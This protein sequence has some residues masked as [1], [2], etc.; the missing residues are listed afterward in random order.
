MQP[1]GGPNPGQPTWMSHPGAPQSFEQNV[2]AARNA[3]G[4]IQGQHQQQQQQQLQSNTIHPS[5]SLSQAQSQGNR[6]G[7]VPPRSGPTP[8]Q[9]NQPGSQHPLG[10]FNI[11]ANA[12]GT[13]FSF[14]A[15][16]TP[17]TAS[18]PSLIQ[19]NRPQ[20]SNLVNSFAKGT[21][22]PLDKARF[23][24]TYKNFCQRKGLKHDQ[25]LLTIDGQTIDLHALHVHVLQEGGSKNVS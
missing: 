18:G 3:T 5:P 7:F 2:Q 24:F 4:Q 19:S 20:G 1:G 22:N 10:S 11:P 15:N 21:I 6:V 9:Q 25:R 13:P 16:G 23:D 14:P 12:M 8:Q 17:P